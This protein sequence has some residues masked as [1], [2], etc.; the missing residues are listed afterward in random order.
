[1]DDL[2]N[3]QPTITMTA[4]TKGLELT[5]LPALTVKESA[6]LEIKHIEWVPPQHAARRRRDKS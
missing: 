6:G 5:D 4:S 3:N 1:M 2:E